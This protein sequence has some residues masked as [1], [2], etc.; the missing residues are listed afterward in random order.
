MKTLLDKLKKENLEKL[1]NNKIK[2]EFSVKRCYNFLSKKHF[3]FELQV[4]E[5]M[6][7]LS[8]TSEK[9]VEVYNL[10]ELFENN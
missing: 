7:I 4:D 8:M 10:N 1:E 3:W 6:L 5:A 9:N 2:Y